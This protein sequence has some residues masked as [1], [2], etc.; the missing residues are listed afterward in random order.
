MQ[1]RLS[2][3]FTLVEMLVVIS[4]IAV[5][6]ALLFP[7]VSGMVE[8]GKITQDLNNLRQIGLGT[9]LYLND[10]DG[11][12]FLPTDNWMKKL[13][14]TTGTQYIPN[15]KIFQSPFDKR[16]PSEVDATAPVSYGFNINAQSTNAGVPTNLLSDKILN[17]SVFIVYA[18]AQPFTK[19]GTDVPVNVTKDNAGSGGAQLG[20]TH[21]R[22][23]RIDAC[24]ADLHVENMAW[25]DFHSDDPDPGT[26]YPVS[27][28]WHPDP[29][30]P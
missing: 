12:F 11:A 7:A 21:G 18:P 2:R 6:A 20:G 23:R 4:I 13:H 27:S 29:A 17:A 22:G 8:K 19:F 30:N 28:R 5:L 10:N 1:K 14:P 3:G 9:Q 15:W 25:S 26:T 16:S 24:F